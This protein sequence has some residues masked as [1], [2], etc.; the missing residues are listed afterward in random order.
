[1][2]IISTAQQAKPKVMGHMEPV[3]AQFINA[4]TLES[5]Y[6][7][8]GPV[9]PP[10]GELDEDTDSNVAKA[11]TVLCNNLVDETLAP[12]AAPVAAAAAAAAVLGNK[13]A[14]TDPSL[15]HTKTPSQD[16]DFNRRMRPSL[17]VWLVVALAVNVACVRVSV[18]EGNERRF[19]AFWPF[20]HF[21]SVQW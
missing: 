14:I 3:R 16:P 17:A 15:T 2:C 21:F 8:P 9:E 6:S 18:C 5:T 1:V 12:T 11:G 7:A 13:V 20:G 10:L 19:K 4:S